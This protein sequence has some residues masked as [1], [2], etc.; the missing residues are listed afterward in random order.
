MAFQD[1]K[2]EILA[3]IAE[4]SCKERAYVNERARNYE[5]L[6]DLIFEFSKTW[7]C[8]TTG[9]LEKMLDVV[10]DSIL[11]SQG[12]Y[13]NKTLTDVTNPRIVVKSN[14]TT[15]TINSPASVVPQLLITRSSNI[16]TVSVENNTDL[17]MLNICGA[18]TVAVLNVTAGSMVEVVLVRACGANIS[19]LQ[20]IAADSNVINISVDE[21]ANYGGIDCPPVTELCAAEITNPVVSGETDSGF[22][23]AWT[24][25][26]T[27]SNIMIYY[28][29]EGEENYQSAFGTHGSGVATLA[30]DHASALFFN[31]SPG[32]TYDILIQN[33]C[34]SSSGYSEG[35]TVQAT[36]TNIT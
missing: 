1:D 22:T 29:E 25:P 5:E 12:I 33:Q 10:D 14:I 21:G 6:A 9:Y 7:D 31:L 8:D 16:S 3:I 19:S 27:S 2:E 13:Y 17:N 20:K 23:V 15:I 34:S 36:T 11:I 4:Q 26:A 24:L 35:V 30:P 32:L 28:R 18:S